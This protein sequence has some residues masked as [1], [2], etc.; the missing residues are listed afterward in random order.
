VIERLELRPYRLPLRAS[1]R[2]ARGVFSGR[3]GWLV[4]ARSAGRVGYGDCAPLP[5][6]GTETPEQASAALALWRAATEGR[7]LAAALALVSADR[8]PAPAARFA[9]ECALLDLAARRARTPL[10]RLL[11]LEA[12]DWVPV[13]ATLGA[14]CGVT[15]PMLRASADAGFGVLK[16]KVGL[17]P[18]ET[19]LARLNK[20]ADG[21]P[22]G[23]GLRLDANGAWTADDAARVIEGLNALPVESLEEP[24]RE[25]EDAVLRRLQSAARFPLGLDESLRS[26]RGTIDLEA[27]PVRRIVLKPAVLGGLRRSLALARRVRDLG[28]EV[29]TTSLIESAAGVW[30]SLQLAAALGSPLAHGLATSGWLA[31][32]LGQ[33]PVAC[34]GRIALPQDPGS[35]FE[36]TTDDGLR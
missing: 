8:T 27:L 18:W 29:V 10:R 2:S 32:D 5:A 24:L 31:R 11:S 12:R 9:V 6:A 20:L 14:L 25:P 7:T 33:P 36:A 35:G 13:N 15:S 26:S 22:T 3:A 4:C 16:I 30:P 19:E 1:W 23:V 34:G 17:E 28:L 21:L